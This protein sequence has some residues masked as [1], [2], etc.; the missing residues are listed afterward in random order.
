MK[1][2]RIVALILTIV[3]FC[4]PAIS[5]DA[6][7]I[8]PTEETQNPSTTV[9]DRYINV[10]NYDTFAESYFEHLKE[11]FGINH[12][13][14][15]GYVALGMLLSYYDTYWNDSII[16]EQYD[17][18][19]IGNEVDMVLRENSPGIV[20]DKLY[21]PETTNS[22]ANGIYSFNYGES[23]SSQDYI[24]K[25]VLMSDEC[26]HS[27]LITISNAL[28]YYNQANRGDYCSSTLTERIDVLNTY[29]SDIAGF[30]S[31]D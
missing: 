13:G 10:L 30:E 19:S 9:A 4:V 16:P 8:T 3:T 28:G 11:N 29:L 27:K 21:A 24:E 2:L 18:S 17:A 25:M 7:Q 31:S 20:A 5:I 6:I 22:D 26:L 12:H 14:S 15:C 23:L 1:K